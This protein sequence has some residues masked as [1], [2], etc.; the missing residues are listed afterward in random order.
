MMYFSIESVRI[1]LEIII[2]A[3]KKRIQ[4]KKEIYDGKIGH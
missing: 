1:W 4:I 2:F 3:D